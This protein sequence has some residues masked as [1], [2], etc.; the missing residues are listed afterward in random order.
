MTIRIFLKRQ[1]Y[2][3]SI[4][5]IAQSNNYVVVSSYKNATYILNDL[6]EIYF[7]I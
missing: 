5:F 3:S 6:K 4:H 7:V 2:V 1:L